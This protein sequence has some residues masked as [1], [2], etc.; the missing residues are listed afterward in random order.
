GAVDR[1]PGW[2]RPA[3]AA[4]ALLVCVGAVGYSWIEGDRDQ[5]VIRAVVY[6]G[7]IASL[8]AHE[9]SHSVVAYWGGDRGIPARGYLTLHPLKFM[10][11]VLSLWLPLLFTVIGGIPLIGGRT[12]VD[13][14]A[15]RSR[16]WDTAVSLAGPGANAVIALGIGALLR[17]EVVDPYSAV[18]AGL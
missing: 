16:W 15:L 12:F 6:G 4:L 14:R 11:P 5:L 18:G 8:V 1:F 2:T 9:F 17:D 3:A 13:R 10:D 7:W